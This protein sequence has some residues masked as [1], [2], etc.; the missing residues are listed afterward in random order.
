MTIK[1]LLWS[2]MPKQSRR[3]NFWDLS[4]ILHYVPE[5]SMCFQ[6][7]CVASPLTKRCKSLTSVDLVAKLC[8][9]SRGFMANYSLNHVN[10]LLNQPICS[11][12]HVNCSLNH[13]NCSLNQS[14]CSLNQ[15][16]CSLNQPNCSLNQANCWHNQS[17]CSL[18]HVR[19]SLY[20]VNCS[21]NHAQLF[22]ESRQ[23]FTESVHLFTESGDSAAQLPWGQ[24]MQRV[25]GL[26]GKLRD[27]AHCR[28]QPCNLGRIRGI[29]YPT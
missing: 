13:A 12:N 15:P 24:A 9:G 21:L 7:R 3:T 14:N 5:G 2:W 4:C 22:I 23:L 25:P 10:C 16:N 17:N 29:L 8:N 19:C 28:C 18:N 27:Q 6:M 11:L 1:L 26:R 20:H